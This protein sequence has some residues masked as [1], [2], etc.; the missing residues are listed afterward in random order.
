MSKNFHGPLRIFYPLPPPPIM[1]I[2]FVWGFNQSLSVLQ[3]SISVIFPLHS[4]VLIPSPLPLPALLPLLLLFSFI[5]HSLFLFSHRRMK[6]LSHFHPSFTLLPLLFQSVFILFP[7]GPSTPLFI[8]YLHPPSSTQE[9]QHLIA[10]P[11]SVHPNPKF[12]LFF[13]STLLLQFCFVFLKSIF[14]FLNIMTWFSLRVRKRRGNGEIDRNG[15][16]HTQNNQQQVH[17]HIS[18]DSARAQLHTVLRGT[19]GEEK[20][21]S[22][23]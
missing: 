15:L 1:I 19:E 17:V 10:N 14:K 5:L 9:S 22:G 4:V 21:G 12:L 2:P 13:L 23:K 6:K 3:L 7:P 11:P 18:L 20:E 8:L 16:C